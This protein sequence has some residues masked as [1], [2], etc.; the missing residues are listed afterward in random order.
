MNFSSFAG[1]NIVTQEMINRIDWR[2]LAESMQP[3]LFEHHFKIK[4]K[5]RSGEIE[6]QIIESFPLSNIWDGKGRRD[7][8]KVIKINQEFGDCLN[9]SKDRLNDKYNEKWLKKYHS[10]Y[11]SIKNEGFKE[12]D[13][14]IMAIKFG[15]EHYYR[16]DGTHRSSVL[17]DLGKKEIRAL[18]F[19]FEELR[20]SFPELDAG[21]ED[22]ILGNYQNYQ[23]IEQSGESRIRDRYEN[24][25]EITKNFWEAKS[26]GDVGCN[27]GYLSIMLGNSGASSVRGFDI[28]ELDI[29]AARIHS[30]RMSKNPEMVSFHGGHV[31]SNLSL[32]LDCEILFFLR[33]IYHLGKDADLLAKVVPKDTIFIIECNKG[34]KKKL[35]E[36]DKIIPRTGK[37][38]A[39]SIN[40]IPFLEERGFEILATMQN[41]DDVI[42]AKK[43]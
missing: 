23:K 41:V 12:T 34:H 16:M 3:S 24:I 28:S 26:V 39:L 31:V 36:P 20:V 13:S 18:I 15:D 42:V 5:Y 27:A 40:L 2:E 11:F 22:W 37:R 43:N 1:T 35:D 7:W 14:P 4:K 30:G 29:A 17:Y 19:D 25:L 38:L 21:Y 6:G 10:L 9:A 33:S 8:I 32:M